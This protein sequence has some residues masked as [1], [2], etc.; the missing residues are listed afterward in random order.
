MA[1]RLFISYASEDASIADGIRSGLEQAGV[2]C[3]IAPRDIEPGTSFPAAITAAIDSCSAQVLLLT[4]QSNA[5]RHVLS[6][7]EHAFN[8]GKPIIAVLIG[9]ITPSPDLQYFISTTHWFDADETF[10][11]ADLTRL[12]TDIEKLLA[13]ER[14]RLDEQNSRRRRRTTLIATAAAAVVLIALIVSAMRWS[15]ATQPTA[16]PPAETPSAAQPSA[17]AVVPTTPAP[18]PTPSVRSKVNAADGQV[19]VWIPPGSFAMG[20]SS[21]DGDC[22]PDELPVHT[23]RIRRGFWL[24]RAE[25]TNA[26]WAKR[27]KPTPKLDRAGTASHPVVSME[28]TEAKR[29]CA[30]IGGRLPTEGEWEYAARAGSRERFYDTLAEIA[31]FE[32]NSD[33]SPHPVGLKAPNAY[34]LYDMLGN[35]SEWVLDRY[36]NKYDDTT[37]EIEEP[38]PPNSSA[39]TRGGAWHSD[40]KGVRVSNRVA[41]E[42]DHADYDTGFRCA[43]DDK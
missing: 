36:Y 11:D 26:E 21:G 4:A 3:W 12:K 33:D 35:V 25:V 23:V 39:V 10:D 42:R 7:V 31:W 19:Y 22:D 30:A 40:A 29:Y 17:P 2:V 8:A 37:T 1:A 16:T 15:R 34:G 20:C 27:M 24:S 14:V 28:R 6:E 18:L 13:G 43:I 9:K 5:S 32:D 38:I 41:V